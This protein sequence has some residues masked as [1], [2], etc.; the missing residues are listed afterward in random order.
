M[1]N[2]PL[3]IN[4]SETYWKFTGSYK[5][6]CNYLP[7]PWQLGVLGVQRL[8]ELLRSLDVQ[9]QQTQNSSDILDECISLRD[10][11]DSLFLKGESND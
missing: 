10:L 1:S 9:N 8:V 6:E 11:F 5:K 3:D 7:S 2:L 4:N